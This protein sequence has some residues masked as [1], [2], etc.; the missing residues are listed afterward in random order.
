MKFALSTLSTAVMTITL[1]SIAAT[2]SAR[3]NEH[4][5][6]SQNEMI[7][8]NVTQIIDADNQN[9]ALSALDMVNQ[10]IPSKTVSSKHAASAN[11]S[12]I[13]EASVKSATIRGDSTSEVSG[14]Q[15]VLSTLIDPIT[16]K[17][18]ENSYP[19]EVSSLLSLE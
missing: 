9:N 12:S 18:I 2:T 13:N 6:E 19:L 1:M 4:M 7:A 3:A 17:S 8:V 5:N 15:A 14:R 11:K 16:H 10:N